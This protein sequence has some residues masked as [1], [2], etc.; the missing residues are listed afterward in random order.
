MRCEAPGDSQLFGVYV[1]PH[2]EAASLHLD[3]FSLQAAFNKYVPAP[4]LDL[5]GLDAAEEVAVARAPDVSLNLNQSIWARSF[6]GAV[7]ND[8]VSLD[9]V[10][11]HLS[12]VYV[13]LS[14]IRHLCDTMFSPF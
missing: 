4:G 5:V 8:E 2:L 14:H 6:N 3:G 1:S 13:D 10:E 12:P 9:D 7:L 11:L